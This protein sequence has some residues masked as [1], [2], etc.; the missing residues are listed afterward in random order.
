MDRSIP[1]MLL[2]VMT[3]MTACGVA[4]TTLPTATPIALP[5]ALPTATP[6]ALPTATALPTTLPDPVSLDTAEAQASLFKAYGEGPVVAHGP[7]SAWD[8]TFTDPGAVLYHDGIFHMFRNGFRAWP[9][10]VQIGYV[11]SKDG[12]SWE[13]QGDQPVFTSAEVPYAGVAALAS[14]ALVL[15]DG[16]WVLYFYTWESN[17]FPSSG[18][19]GRASAP[20][21]TGPWTADPALVL[22]PGSAGEWDES[23]VLSADVQRTADGYVM[24]YSGI[25]SKGMQMIG[26]AT[27]SDGISW[28]KYND[29]ASA[30]PF[31]ESDPV[32]GPGQSGAWDAGFVHQ[33]R[34]A[35]SADGWVMLYRGVPALRSNKMALG[36]A[37]S[38]DGIHWQRLPAPVLTRKAV[39]NAEAFWYTSMLY[40]EGSYFL[41][42]EVDMRHQTN[43]YLATY[44]G[45]LGP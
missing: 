31:A 40:H 13:K 43:I 25:N 35:H 5:T 17:N 18:G 27:S 29:P 22:R 11:R 44:Q 19:I 15:D 6:T 38:S 34:V 12:Y 10:S 3:M 28:V 45:K 33:P 30:A 42:W 24:Y 9:A 7:I 16:T 39:P 21:P 8:G 2:L 20:S 23:Q 32:F 4:P 41:F 26:M 36:A 37:T 14:S 1:I